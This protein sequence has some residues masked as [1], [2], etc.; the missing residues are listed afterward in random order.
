MRGEPTPRYDVVVVGGGPAGLNAALM[1]A[2]SRRS[3]LVVDAG[4]PRNGP[5]DGV[6][7]LLGHDGTPPGE[8]LERGRGEVRRYGGEVV[9]GEV[10]AAARDG[11][12]FIVKIDGDR[13]VRTRRLL[14]TTGAFDELPDIP[15]VRERWGRDVLH[16]AYCHGW[17]VRDKAIGVLATAPR[18]LHQALL[19]RQLSDDVV[20]FTH[21]TT[22]TGDEAERIR[23]RG[24]R[25]VTGEVAALSVDD[26]RVAGVRLRSGDTVAREALV[27]ATRLV[28]RTPFVAQLDLETAEHPS[29][30]GEHIVVEPGG[31]AAVPG[32]W[33]AGNAID[34]SA[35]VG[36]AAAAGAAAAAQI[37][38]DLVEE[39]TR[40]ALE[41]AQTTTH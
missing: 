16:C 40:V 15:G 1:L 4:S 3:V 28:V 26:D 7:G 21:E 9:T 30:L 14:L 20:Y 36:G 33:A 13:I 25:M 17:E 6:H 10:T 19:F 8:L 34:P 22:P 35:Q 11:D 29:G 39:D 12:I 31:R 23:A 18:S 5:A 41:D 24:I 27:V 38:A 2:R 32:V 37:N